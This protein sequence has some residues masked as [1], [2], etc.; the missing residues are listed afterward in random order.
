M[1]SSVRRYEEALSMAEAAVASRQ[2]PGMHDPEGLS[3][4]QSIL[5]QIYFRLGRKEESRILH[6]QVYATRLELFSEDHPDTQDTLEALQELDQVSTQ[7]SDVE[8][9]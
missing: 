7:F 4:A 3:N 6:T 9:T 2:E 5:A 1:D 8:M